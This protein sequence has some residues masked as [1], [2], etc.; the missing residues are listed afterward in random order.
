MS[1]YTYLFNKMC[2]KNDDKRDAGLKFPEDVR[3]FR[4]ILYGKSKKWQ[5]LDVYKPLKD[6]DKKIPTL[7][8]IHGGGWCYGDKERYQYYCAELAQKGFAVINFTYRL[9]S[10]Y[11]Y[12]AQLEDSLA[13]LKWAVANKDE[14]GF[15]LSNLFILGDSAGANMAA[16]IGAL[17]TSMEYKN[18]VKKEVPQ[19]IK[20]KALGLNCG[21][22][23]S[24]EVPKKDRLI[25]MM[26]QMLKDCLGF[27]WKQKMKKLAVI[28]YLTKDF[29]PCY[30]LTGSA[31]FLKQ[32]GIDLNAKLNELKVEH[33]F[34]VY[35]DEKNQ[36][37]HVFFLDLHNPD[38]QEAIDDEIRF[39]KAYID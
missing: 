8:S 19:G 2:I 21:L 37:G 1:L 39:F 12:P 6:A 10:H 35:G 25:K 3:A 7:I 33:G 5:I 22:Y 34:K 17:L 26:F 27:G 14:Y 29:F 32:N 20:P 31:D 38:G 4:N 15:D 30:V 28:D 9:G 11:K 24:M 18:L 36:L 23:E 13:V 16:A